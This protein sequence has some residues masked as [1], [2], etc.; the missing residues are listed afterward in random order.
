[1][2]A[3][4]DEVPGIAIIECFVGPIYYLTY[5]NEGDKSVC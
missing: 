5:M 1:M 3:Y 2:C 4:L